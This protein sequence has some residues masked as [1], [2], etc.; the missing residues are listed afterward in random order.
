MKFYSSN[1]MYKM[2]SE[3]IVGQIA[4]HLRDIADL[5]DSLNLENNYKTE[6]KKKG[7]SWKK[8]PESEEKNLLSEIAEGL[9][10]LEIAQ[11]HER[12]SGSI[13]ARLR[14]IAL[15]YQETGHTLQNIR[16]L[17]GLTE[18]EIIWGR[19]QVNTLNELDDES[20][21]EIVCVL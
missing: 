9:S 13:F 14:K 11:K 16:K 1:K 10:R 20:E 17:T 21:E 6:V 4:K 7:R 15:K 3:K 5:L 18:E 2:S 12:T 8:W 19:E